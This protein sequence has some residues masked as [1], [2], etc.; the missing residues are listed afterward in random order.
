MSQPKQKS[1][2]AI[3]PQCGQYWPPSMDE[4]Y[5]FPG[6]GCDLGECI[7]PYCEDERD[8][9]IHKTGRYAERGI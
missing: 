9:P 6:S 2:P 7:C 8:C 3:C 5:S 4:S 1:D